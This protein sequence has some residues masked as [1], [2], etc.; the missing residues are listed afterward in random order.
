VD[1][2]GWDDIN[3]FLKEVPIEYPVVLDHDQKADED[4]GPLPGLPVTIFID[5]QGRIV[6]RS[7]GIT[8]IDELRQTIEANL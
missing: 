3:K 7:L 8:D 6:H 5:R 4:F 1:E 2:G